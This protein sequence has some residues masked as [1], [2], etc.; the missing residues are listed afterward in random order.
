[1]SYLCTNPSE[2]MCPR[3]TPMKIAE[4]HFNALIGTNYETENYKF[5]INDYI[6]CGTFGSVYNVTDHISKKNWVLKVI[7]I[8]K[9]NKF[10][11]DVI[12]KQLD[13][14]NVIQ[15]KGDFNINIDGYE[16]SCL[17]LEKC[18]G[19]LLDFIRTE[20]LRKNITKF[21]FKDSSENISYETD[22]FKKFFREALEALK[23]LTDNQIM[24]R[25][26]KPDNILIHNDKLIICDFGSA[27]HYSEDEENVV[28]ICS[29][30][31]RAP[32]LL[33]NKDKRMH[34]YDCKID[35]W[36]IGIVFLEFIMGKFPFVTKGDTE[37][38]T[39]LRDLFN[40]KIDDQNEK[41]EKDSKKTESLEKM[42]ENL[43]LIDDL[44][45]VLLNCLVYEPDKRFSAE[46]LLEL[47]YFK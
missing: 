25:D 40:I 12:T 27:K 21:V 32:E 47:Q 36:S 38:L 44:K 20:N 3:K 28:Y 16:Y 8:N 46:K 6:G 33:E 18:N 15:Y 10:R 42:L 45:N 5:T 7:F 4:K 24:H 26:I 13:H 11:E 37:L 30:L 1:M 43:N 22:L 31:Y 29:R 14:P 9:N 17:L 35:V 34:K 23:Y 41:F 39:I 2:E 19:L